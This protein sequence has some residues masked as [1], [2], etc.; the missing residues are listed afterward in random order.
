M[1]SPSAADAA[2]RGHAD[3]DGL[4][5]FEVEHD[6]P[7]IGRRTMLLSGRRI[8]PTGVLP[9]RLLLTIEDITEREQ[10]REEL[11]VLDSDLEQRATNRTALADTPLISFA[12]W[13]P[14]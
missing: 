5:D 4:Q 12:N 11:G 1:G 3:G 13:H 10:D 8:Q 6:F 14:N 7:Q 2:R 9:E